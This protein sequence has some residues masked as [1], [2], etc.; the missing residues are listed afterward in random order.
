MSL[1]AEKWNRLPSEILGIKQ[2]LAAF[3]V[4]EAARLML[5]MYRELDEKKRK[6]VRWSDTLTDDGKVKG[7][8]NEAALQ[9]FL[10]QYGEVR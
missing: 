7:S 10:E 2:E 5:Y 6:V 4:D 1:T 9:G 3:C 8:G